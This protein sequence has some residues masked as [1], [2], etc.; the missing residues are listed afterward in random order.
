MLRAYII[1]VIWTVLTSTNGANYPIESNP[2]R[3]RLL[4]QLSKWKKK[5]FRRYRSTSLK[6]YK[7][8][9]NV[10]AVMKEMMMNLMV[11]K[12]SMILIMI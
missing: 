6:W 3:L 1:L 8:K 10:R 9:D 5:T 12:M 11:I 4:A 2:R 7:K